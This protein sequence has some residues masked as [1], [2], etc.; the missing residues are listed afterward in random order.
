MTNEQIDAFLQKNQ[1]DRVPVKVSF[2]TRNSFTGIFIKANDY[3]DLKTKNFWRIVSESNVKKYMTSKDNSL[4]R[5]Y[6]G[7]EITKLA[8][9]EMFV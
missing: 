7:T 9:A 8:S 3:E 2:K 4:A 1:Y 5:I 6:S